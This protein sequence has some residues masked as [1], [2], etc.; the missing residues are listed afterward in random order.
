ML[1]ELN[2]TLYQSK[3]ASS[4]FQEL[5]ELIQS[6]KAERN[7]DISGLKNDM[8]DFKSK[9]ENTLDFFDTRLSKIDQFRIELTE[10]MNL[11]HQMDQKMAK[12]KDSLKK[13]LNDNLEKQNADIMEKSRRITMATHKIIEI[14]PVIK[15][16][17]SQFERFDTVS[18]GNTE[19][20]AVLKQQIEWFK[21]NTLEL[22]THTA[23]KETI[24]TS[25]R[26]LTLNYQL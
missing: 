22:S 18:K 11:Y 17:E 10:A 26:E 20:I 6:I 1:K 19:N 5:E 24:E 9:V 21:L 3:D 15:R 4:K 16:L 7:M 14:E 13:E 12:Y 25:V 23:F 8:T 2:Y